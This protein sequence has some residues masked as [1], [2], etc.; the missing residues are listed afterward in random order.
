MGSSSPPTRGPSGTHR[1]W[2]GRGDLVLHLVSLVTA[3][4]IPPTLLWTGNTS[5]LVMWRRCGEGL[6]MPF[7]WGPPS[8]AAPCRLMCWA[9]QEG[10]GV[11]VSPWRESAEWSVH[12]LPPTKALWSTVVQPGG[13][14]VAGSRACVCVCWC[15]KQ[16]SRDGVAPARD[17][18]A[19]GSPRSRRCRA[20][21]TPGFCGWVS[22][23]VLIRPMGLATQ[24]A[25]PTP[26]VA[27]PSQALAQAGI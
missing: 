25:W 1:Q 21:A 5:G 11:R 24:P 27:S 13:E 10:S 4:P 3:H 20:D 18:R 14:H 26:G 15:G 8:W 12:S 9:G 19:T 16:G 6:A 23:E 22:T 17:K 7:R 2:Q